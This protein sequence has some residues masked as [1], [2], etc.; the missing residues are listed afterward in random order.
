MDP[1]AK[2]DRVEDDE[3]EQSGKIS[4]ACLNLQKAEG[5]IGIGQG[6]PIGDQGPKQDGEGAEAEEKSDQAIADDEHSG[7]IIVAFFQNA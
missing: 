2:I 3:Q 7:L 6:G 4:Q 5:G 1:V